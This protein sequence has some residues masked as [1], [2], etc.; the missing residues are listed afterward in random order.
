MPYKNE[1]KSLVSIIVSGIG[2]LLISGG[3]FG[4]GLWSALLILRSANI[5]DA[6]ISYRHCVLLGYIYV[7]FIT[8]SK[9]LLKKD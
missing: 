6:I 4:S 2:G 7:I 5:V 3:I 9:Q 1:N 8:Y